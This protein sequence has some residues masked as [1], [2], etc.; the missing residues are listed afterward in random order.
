LISF[1]CSTNALAEVTE[2][3]TLELKKSASLLLSAQNV[4]SEKLPDE[5]ENIDSTEP[6]PLTTTMENAHTNS[7]HDLATQC[8]TWKHV[9]SEHNVFRITLFCIDERFS[10]HSTDILKV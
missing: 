1:V 4:T 6:I 3:E 9:A 8:K 5:Q 10:Q 2:E 7:V